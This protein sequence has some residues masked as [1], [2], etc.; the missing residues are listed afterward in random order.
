MEIVLVAGMWLDG[1][2]WSDVASALTS[3]GHHPVPLWLPGQGDGSASASLDDQLAAV[4]AAVDAAADPSMVVGHSA[5]ASLAWMAVDARPDK[6]AKVVFIGGF[7]AAD[8]TAYFDV[9]DPVDGAVR[10]PGWEPF[11]GTD[12]ADLDE[13]TKRRIA[14]ATVPVPEAVTHAVVH[15]RDDRRYRVPVVVVC[16][17]FSAAQAKEWVDTGE[18]PELSKA[19]DVSFVDIE[20]GHW[21]MFSQPSALAGLLG[22]LAHD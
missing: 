13:E 12:S 6:V 7:P 19:Y 9:F 22:S 16:P 4:V 14:T 17:E 20:S 10:F 3:L 18:L 1:S 2:A 15:L 8:G 21:P 11:E 5:A